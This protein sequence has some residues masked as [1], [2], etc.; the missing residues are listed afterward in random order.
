MFINHVCD[1]KIDFTATLRKCRKTA[2]Y[3]QL[4]IMGSTEKNSLK[5]NTQDP[6]VCKN[7]IIPSLSNKLNN[8]LKG[9]FENTKT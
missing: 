9:H 6:C 8:Q 7:S 1:I 2:K 3:L 5:P 4:L